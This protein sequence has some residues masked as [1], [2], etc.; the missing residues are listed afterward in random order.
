MTLRG[1]RIAV[2]G[3]AGGI[4]LATVHRLVAAGAR[5]ACL[6]IDDTGLER[7]GK[8]HQVFTQVVD[9]T[10]SE[11]IR[12]AIGTFAE[13][14][15]GLDGL[16]NCAGIDL[17]CPV[18][19][20]SDEQWRRLMAV[21]LDGPMFACRAALPHLKA[22]GGG[23]IVNVSSGAGLRPLNHRAA[24]STSK[25][26]LQMLSKALALEAGEYGIRINAVCPGAVDTPLL[27]GSFDAAPD[28][29]EEEQAVKAR[30][31]LGRIASADEVAAAIVWLLSDEAS[32]V[33]GTAMPVD[34]G[35]AFH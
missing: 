24:Y 3:G 23:S 8:T 34:G 21:N 32:F 11:D 30:Y 13:E 33:T 27:Q 12:A 15:G 26:A 18:E 29:H 19:Q 25:A 28:P 31:A 17:L 20:M 7:L 10:R 5:T 22:S 4:G 2:T 16:V 14:A 6:D 35:R 1:R 9:I